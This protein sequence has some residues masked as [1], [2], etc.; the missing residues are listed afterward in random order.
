M[1]KLKALADRIRETQL[2]A[3]NNAPGGQANNESTEL[4]TTERKE[5]KKTWH[6]SEKREKSSEQITTGLIEDIRSLEI[7]ETGG[8]YVH[9]RISAQMH[10]KLMALKLA[11]VSAQKFGA[12]ALLQLLE[13][14]EIKKHI[15]KI[16]NDLE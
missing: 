11:K 6:Q 13:H 9:L 16:L 7:D 2:A 4:N 3:A 15:K 10:S 8:T 1:T 12:F 5:E 14:P